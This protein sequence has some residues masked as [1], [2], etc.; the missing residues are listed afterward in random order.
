[1]Y[2]EIPDL[3]LRSTFILG[4][5]GE[6]EAHVTELLDF[7]DT[8]PF[9][10]IGC[11]TYSE[12]RETRSARYDNKVDM[13]TAHQRVDQVMAHQFQL[14]QKRQPSLFGSNTQMIYEGQGIARSYKEA[15]DV[16]SKIIITEHQSLQPGQFFTG[17]ITGAQG[18]DLT[19]T[20]V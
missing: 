2:N 17:K 9:S 8:H 4:F 10:Q 5:P 11:F 6:T 14:V 12:E 13:D 7:I 19:G 3:S 16:D 18:Y 1:M 15:P 20:P